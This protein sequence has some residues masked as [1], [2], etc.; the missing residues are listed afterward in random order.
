M[1]GQSTRVVVRKLFLFYH[2]KISRGVST[3][4]I[5]CEQTSHERRWAMT[6]VVKSS[7]ESRSFN[8][9]D[10]AEDLTTLTWSDRLISGRLQTA[11]KSPIYCKSHTTKYC[12]MCKHV[13]LH[14]CNVT[15][16]QFKL[17]RRNGIY[18]I[19]SPLTSAVHIAVVTNARNNNI[20]II[21]WL[22]QKS[23][24]VQTLY[25]VSI[26]G[27]WHVEKHA[28]TFTSLQLIPAPHKNNRL[29]QS[30]PNPNFPPT[31]PIAPKIL[32]TSLPIDMCMCI[33]FDPDWLRL[34]GVISERLICRT[35]KMI[36]I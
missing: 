14:D 8:D 34:A 11:L 7:A 20:F 16:H 24:H 10:S 28:I 29:R 5:S 3:S 1:F 25:T 21:V 2:T 36:T 26:C 22:L 9:R 19:Y 4:S 12:G 35:L 18:C 23:K 33:Q 15:K 13:S 6:V 32:W 30:R 31:W 27:N 17:R